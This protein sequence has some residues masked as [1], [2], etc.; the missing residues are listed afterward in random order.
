LWLSQSI[1][2]NIIVTFCA[3]GTQSIHGR[4]RLNASNGVRTPLEPFIFF[5]VDVLKATDSA[6]E[7]AGFILGSQPASGRDSGGM[8]NTVKE[9]A[10][11][12]SIA[13]TV[14]FSV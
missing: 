14:L 2:S 7:L 5:D 1:L 6:H 10:E 8:A 11:D 4:G 3:G 13:G 9:T 12:S